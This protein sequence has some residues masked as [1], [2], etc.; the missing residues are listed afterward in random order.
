MLEAEGQEQE[1]RVQKT[2]DRKDQ[3]S[4]ESKRTQ[5]QQAD[6]RHQEGRHRDQQKDALRDGYL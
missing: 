6:E 1:E 4:F 5:L 2:L 3:R